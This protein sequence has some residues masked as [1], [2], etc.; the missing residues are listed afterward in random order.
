[1]S[2]SIPNIQDDI[3]AREIQPPGTTPEKETEQQAGKSLPYR[4]QEREWI[5][6]HKEV[7]QKLAGQWIVVEGEELVSHGN[8]P[9]QVVAEARAKGIQIPDIIRVGAA[10]KGEVQIGL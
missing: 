10:R 6:T 2:A 4:H 8:D 9:L 7:V 5:R 1:M 3:T